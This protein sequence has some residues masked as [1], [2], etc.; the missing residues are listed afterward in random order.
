MIGS[1]L[2]SR[3]ADYR[4]IGLVGQG[5]FAQVY[6]AVH[7]STG[8]LVAIKQT[9]HLRERMSQEAAILPQLNY[10]G[11]VSCYAVEHTESGDQFILE[12]C[13]SGTLR[14]YLNSSNSRPFELIQSWL[15]SLLKSLSYLHKKEIIHDDIKP[16]N[17][18]LAYRSGA[19]ITKLSD[20]GNARYIGTLPKSENELARENKLSEQD[21]GSPTYAAPERFAGYASYASD[22]YSVGITLYEML[23][24]DRPF[25]GTPQELR[26]AH[27]NQP[28]PKPSHLSPSAIRLLNKALHKDPAQRF[29]SADDM[30]KALQQLNEPYQIDKRPQPTRAI[31]S[32]QS[33][34]RSIR[35]AIAP[36]DIP[37]PV[38]SLI[39]TSQGCCVKTA[40]ALYQLDINQQ[41]SLIESTRQDTQ[42]A[43]APNHQWLVSFKT[44]AA[45]DTD[46]QVGKL[47]F[48]D[49]HRSQTITL[50]NASVENNDEARSQI[51]KILALN[52]RYLLRIRTSANKAK[53]QLECF[54]RR[55]QFIGQCSID[56]ALTS[57]SLA[58]APYQ[59][60][61]SPIL[62][63]SFAHAATVIS[64]KPFQIRY[65][66]C[67]SQP[68]CVAATSWGYIVVCRQDILFFDR[69]QNLLERLHSEL[70]V[71]AIAPLTPK[72][73][74]LSTP[75]S[76]QSYLHLINLDQ[77]PLD[78]I[79]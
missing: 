33:F 40:Y 44:P 16:E 22:L 55:G 48:L 9:R 20:F 57:V 34:H 23:V 42:I 63:A 45:K 26:H 6:C 47:H 51:I 4:L 24:G 2:V 68:Q 1:N 50:E 19:M 21:I 13:E 62:S 66:P 60:I 78:I 79:F 29:T 56:F 18:L 38:E 76:T 72:Q 39:S 35:D 27:Q 5:Q 65:L 61:A 58:H 31:D 12:Y 32:A 41:I 73:I 25:S 46:K 17:I 8:Q 15:V 64:L 3:L 54:S 11:I 36:I 43:I 30:C 67:H 75:K 53:T 14:T 77:L 71:N 52:K 10:S 69:E 28:V 7:R 70:E 49:T 59:L 37:A 74:L